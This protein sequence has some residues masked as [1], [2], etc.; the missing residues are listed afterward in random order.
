MTQA[1]IMAAGRSTR[2][3]PLTK[4][5]P[6]PLL[7]IANKTILE[8]NLDALE[9]FV[10]EVI[11]I[12]HY[13]K[14]MIIERFRDSYK[15]LKLTYV[16][17]KVPKGTG[18]A[19]L[20]AEKHIRSDLIVLNGDDIYSQ[21]DLRRMIEHGSA[22]LGLRVEDP[23]KFGALVIEDGYLSKIVEK[24]PEFVSD[25][26]N[27]GG[28]YLDRSIFDI[29]KE[30]PL[31]PRGEYELTDA[32]SVYAQKNKLRVVVVDD[33]WLPVGYP[34]HILD[35]TEFFLARMRGSSIQGKIDPE[36]SLS[37]NIACKEGSTISKGAK[38]SA[39]VMIGCN[40]HIE[41]GAQI[42]PN[43]TI[44]DR[45]RVGRGSRIANSVVFDDCRIGEN[46][47]FSFSVCG[48]GSVIE[49]N[50]VIQTCRDD[51][52][53]IFTMI[54]DVMQDSGRNELGTIIGDF[55]CIRKGTHAS[56]GI[57][58]WPDVGTCENEDIKEDK[59]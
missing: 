34:W 16:D 37:G 6:K 1:V 40:S 52:S 3:Y 45:C 49:D 46:V 8:H 30:I 29:L 14:E 53:N 4:T 50:V 5:R 9:P 32:I 19:V 43:T 17:Q 10:D 58:V 31:S 57:K 42:G 12:V 54:K 26:V 48:F 24:S 13:K 47:D 33:F 51:R 7:K 56:C 20:Q 59:K 23:A 15:G 2:T 21:D 55:C 35:A 27:V 38:I 41:P 28:Y 18:H 25:I 44:G 22:I 36:L 39:P 11:L